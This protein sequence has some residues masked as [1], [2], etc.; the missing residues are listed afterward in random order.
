[1]EDVVVYQEAG[2]RW[3]RLA[4]DARSAVGETIDLV[5]ETTGLRLGSTIRVRLTTTDGFAL[6]FE[7]HARRLSERILASGVLDAIEDPRRRARV[8]AR[9]NRSS[10]MG[11]M[12][13]THRLLLCRPGA[14]VMPADDGHPEIFLIPS[15][16]SYPGPPARS[17]RLTI[18]HELAHAAQHIAAP[19]H[20]IEYLSAILTRNSAD[21]RGETAPQSAALKEGHA[22]WCSREVM[23]AM[24]GEP[25]ADRFPEDPR[26]SLR[27]AM[28][29][30]LSGPLPGFRRLQRL[31]DGAEEFVR[32]VLAHGGT[33]LVNRIWADVD[34]LP[35]AHEIEDPTRWLTRTTDHTHN[36]ASV[37]ADQSK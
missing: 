1:M 2:K 3:N 22:R 33:D 16:M 13:S 20:P 19:A 21:R 23:S 37:A 31:R 8:K 18:A 17:L 32:Q 10:A 29:D 4:D 7:Q 35:R 6:A 36:R 11:P 9:F 15:F 34:L 28:V 14:S 26:G 27:L 25:V 5:E 24:Y 12:T 30:R